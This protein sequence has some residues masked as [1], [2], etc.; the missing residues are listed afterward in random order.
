M[1]I[2]QI[3]GSIILPAA[4][5]ATSVELQKEYDYIAAAI[6]TGRL[7]ETGLITAD[8]YNAIMQ[9]NMESLSPFSKRVI[10]EN[11]IFHAVQSD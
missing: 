1:N 10:T 4:S 6:V 11:V 5:K 3:D 7:L 9:Q 2:T 8:E